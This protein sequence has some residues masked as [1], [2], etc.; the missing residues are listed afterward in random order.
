MILPVML[1]GLLL[2][3]CGRSP[4]IADKEVISVSIA[5]FRYF[6]EYI[7]GD[8]YTVNIMVPASADPHFYEPTMAQLRELKRSV[9]YIGN[10]YLDFELAWLDKFI[11]ANPAMK[12]L[13][14]ADS[15]DLIY[16]KTWEHDDHRHYEGVDPHFWVSPRS[17]LLIASDI[18]DLLVGL[19]PEAGEI[20]GG[21]YTRLVAEIMSVD[22]EMKAL[23]A[24]HNGMPFMIYHPV[25]GYFARDY[26][27]LQVPVEY[28]GKEPSPARLVN[29]IGEA[30][31][32]EIGVILVQKEF[33]E[34]N[35]LAIASETG[36][37]VVTIEPLSENWPAAVR[38]IGA[39][40]AGSKQ[41]RQED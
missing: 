13:T 4:G 14:L 15:Q 36:V 32:M 12:V 19:R 2:S 27:L 24:S 37:S 30:R 33:D 17:A 16:A 10:G 22:S 34:K 1:T 25:L 39:A 40:I 6:T 31:N 38:A 11:H 20:Y 35:A 3:F 29:I 28:E 8:D 18:R 23:F 21:N 9:A 41:E 5:P 26:A 7:A